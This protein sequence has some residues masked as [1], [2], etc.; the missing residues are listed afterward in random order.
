MPPFL[1]PLAVGAATAAARTPV[2]FL[3]IDSATQP[4][5]SLPNLQSTQL[6]AACVLQQASTA[7]GK[8]SEW[9]QHM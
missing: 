7:A 6:G 1:L 8:V 5:N 2:L 3:Q 9:G 4:E